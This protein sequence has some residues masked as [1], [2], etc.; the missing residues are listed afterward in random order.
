LKGTTVLLKVGELSEYLAKRDEATLSAKLEE[1]SINDDATELYVKTGFEESKAF[2]LDDTATKALASYLKVPNN[3]LSKVTPDFKAT[4]LRYELERKSSAQTVVEA[5]GG[6]LIN[7]HQPTQTM[8]PLARVG[9]VV[10]KVMSPEDTIRR[11]ILNDARF[12]LDV[13]TAANRVSFHELTDTTSVQEIDSAV[14]DITEGGLRV[15]AYPFQNRKPSVGAYLE[16]LICTNG[17]TTEE[18]VGAIELK[19][20]T[21]DEV[22]AA[23]EIAAEAV[24]G[25]LDAKLSDYSHT[26]EMTPPGSPQAFVAQLAAEANLSRAALNKVL[27][28][29]NQLPEPVSVWDVNQAFTSVANE[30]ETYAAMTRLQTL[31]GSLAMDAHKMVER[32]HACERRLK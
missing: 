28:I 29:I 11:V 13:T 9:E 18:K 4:L 26:R 32:C 17:M 19:G 25:S 31:G 10:T 7:F 3:Y 23:M 5:L 15:L 22:I 24:L 2:T 20:S 30:V 8:L 27:D 16:R 12:H 1:F 14:G 6:H 21:V